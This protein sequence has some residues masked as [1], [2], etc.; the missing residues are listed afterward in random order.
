VFYFTCI[1][2]EKKFRVVREK[3]KDR[4]HCIFSR[5]I[6]SGDFWFVILPANVTKLNA[7]L[8]LK[9]ILS[10]EKVVSFGNQVNDIEMFRISD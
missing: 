10:C 4:Y 2:D 5:D 7:V 6:Y 8:K 1:D 3:L 9:E